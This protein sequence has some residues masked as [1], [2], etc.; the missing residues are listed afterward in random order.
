MCVCVLPAC[1]SWYCFLQ[2]TVRKA[3]QCQS[4]CVACVSEG[5]AARV[6]DQATGV[7]D[8]WAGQ[9]L[10]CVLTV[11]F[12][13]VVLQLRAIA[14]VTAGHMAVKLQYILYTAYIHTVYSDINTQYIT[15]LFI[16]NTL[17]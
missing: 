14:C 16:L 10:S 7:L 8:I 3:S 1:V 15:S 12:S 6:K 17:Q 11:C 9:Q 4:C 5:V 2:V 13:H